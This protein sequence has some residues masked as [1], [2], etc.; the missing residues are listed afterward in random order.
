MKALAVDKYADFSRMGDRDD[1]RNIL[2]RFASSENAYNS[3][4]LRD[5]FK[6]SDELK[7]KLRALP[8]L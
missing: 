2:I 1:L 7:L 6:D 3:T 4:E 5:N 8:P